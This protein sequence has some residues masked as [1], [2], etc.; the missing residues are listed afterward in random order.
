MK[1]CNTCQQAKEYSEFYK[2]KNFKDGYGYYCIPCVQAKH[3]VKTPRK[4]ITPEYRKAKRK[5]FQNSYFN[6]WGG[7]IYL[8]ITECSNTYVGSSKILRHRRDVHSCSKNRADSC[9]AGNY[10]VKTFKI[11][12]KIENYSLQNARIREQYWIEKL[13]PTLNKRSAITVIK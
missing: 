6:S 5:E 9:I 1:I 3:N 8:V 12:E 13:Q 2:N 7:G 11:L 4:N 10:K